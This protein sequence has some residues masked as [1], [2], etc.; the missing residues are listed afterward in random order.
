MTAVVVTALT[1]HSLPANGE[2]R[3]VELALEND[4]DT[5][6]SAQEDTGWTVDRYE[7][8]AVMGEAVFSVCQVD[9]PARARTLARL[10]RRISRLGGPLA[11]A[12]AK[13]G[14]IDQHRALLEATRSRDL[15]S[16]AVERADAECAVWMT[17]DPSFRGVHSNAQRFTINLEGGGLL[18][19]RTSSNKRNVGAGGSLRLLLGR[20]F[21]HDYSMLLG[22]EFGGTALF[23]K[24]DAGTEFPLSFVVAAPLVFRH[25]FLTWHHDLEVA[26]IFHFTDDDKDLSYGARVGTLLGIA[27]PRIRNIKP[28]AGLATSLEFVFANDTRP[29]IGAFRAG[30]RIGFDWDY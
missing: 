28:W 24:T 22:G 23:R 26:P 1:L 25:R 14:D 13:T 9:A 2:E 29:A 7:F 19:A 30:L 5:L 18:E 20:G 21:D 17:P 12:V 27:R 16:I 8:E 3:A 4:I 15:L 11:E 6:V 10:E